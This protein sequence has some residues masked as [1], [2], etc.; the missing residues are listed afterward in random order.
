MS[1][2]ETMV[3]WL[4]CARCPDLFLYENYRKDYHVTVMR[5]ATTTVDNK[6][7]RLMMMR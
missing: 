3:S 2:E 6:N 1:F 5:M 4:M 7:E